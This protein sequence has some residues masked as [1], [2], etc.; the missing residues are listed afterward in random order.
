[1]PII[2][3]RIRNFLSETIRNHEFSHTILHQQVLL[4][5]LKLSLKNKILFIQQ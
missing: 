1:M 4:K 5:N 2:V 3:N